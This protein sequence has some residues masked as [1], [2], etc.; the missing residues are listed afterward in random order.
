MRN[1]RRLIAGAVIAGLATL[2]TAGVA[3]AQTTSPSTTEKP[4]AAKLCEKAR[5]RLPRLAERKATNEERQAK[6]QA[7]IDK[8]KA[9]GKNDLA[10]RLQTRLDNVKQRHDR[11]VDLIARINARCG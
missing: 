7:A 4:N 10:Q 2:G 6:L 3:S 1:V 11:I 9:A 8:A 5:D